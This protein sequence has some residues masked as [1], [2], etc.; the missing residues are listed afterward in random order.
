[1]AT[2]S[3][4]TTTPTP[5]P[6]GAW[7]DDLLPP[8][9]IRDDLRGA[10]V[11]WHREL[12]TFFRNRLRILIALVQPILF[13][14]VLGT[15]LASLTSASSGDVSYQTFMFPG[16]LAL[17]VLMPSFFSAGSIVFDREFGFLREMLVAPM[18]RGTIVVGKCIGGATVAGVQGVL[19][20]ALAGVVDVPYDPVLMLTLLL[21]LLL[22]SFVLVAFGVMMAARITQFQSF[23]AVVQLAIFPMLFLSGAMFPLNGLPRWLEVLTRLD[24]VTYAV[25]PMRHAVFQHLDASPATRATL[26]PGI[27]WVG[28][29][30]PTWLSL[31]IVAVTGITMLWIAI[32]E[33]QRMD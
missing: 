13:L 5:S 1:M 31:V 27:T 3:T 6:Y 9:R 16:V 25:E 10:R 8:N 23:M 11:V 20:L 15:G 21:E 33:F 19:V 12:I 2:T 22:L 18:R 28:W 24:P 26:D 7:D 30:V 17:A 14:F 4:T 32:L 29:L